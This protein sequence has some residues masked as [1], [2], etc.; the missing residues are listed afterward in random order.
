[1]CASMARVDPGE[2]RKREARRGLGELVKALHERPLKSPVRVSVEVA[3][4]PSYSFRGG[5]LLEVRGAA[6]EQRPEEAGPPSDACVRFRDETA[7]AEVVMQ[8]R[9]AL[10]T[11]DLPRVVSSLLCQLAMPGWGERTVEVSGTTALA[12]LVW[13]ACFA[14]EESPEVAAAAKQARD[15]QRQAWA[16]DDL[17]QGWVVVHSISPGIR[18]RVAMFQRELEAGRPGRSAERAASVAASAADTEQAEASWIDELIQNLCQAAEEFKDSALRK[19]AAADPE[20]WKKSLALD[21]GSK[22]AGRSLAA[23]PA[24]VSCFI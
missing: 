2:E 15:A 22:D 24:S 19:A 16:H 11:D 5:R 7:L 8:I 21:D 3:G 13:A 14:N 10:S 23:P 17:G 1:M 4:V 6:G 9:D 20:L 12:R 18:E